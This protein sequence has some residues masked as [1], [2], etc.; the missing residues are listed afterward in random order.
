MVKTRSAL[1]EVL[2]DMQSVMLMMYGARGTVANGGD[3]VFDHHV[4]MLG[5]GATLQSGTAL[6]GKTFI[7]T[8]PSTGRKRLATAGLDATVSETA[9]AKATKIDGTYGRMQALATRMAEA[10]VELPTSLTAGQTAA[11]NATDATHISM[12]NVAA[13]TTDRANAE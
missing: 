4:G 3:G 12:A 5:D 8:D 2:C 11:V 6:H 1:A 7:F 10:G 13:M 9:H